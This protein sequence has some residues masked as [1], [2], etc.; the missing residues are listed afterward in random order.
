MT[1]IT[2]STVH[3]ATPVFIRQLRFRVLELQIRHDV[4]GSQ[5]SVDPRVHILTK[6]KAQGIHK[7]Q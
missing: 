2:A 6:Y 3:L 5:R 4:F 1:Q 7:N